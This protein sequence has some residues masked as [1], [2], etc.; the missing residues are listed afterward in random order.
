MR[1]LVSV[2]K[3][4]DKACSKPLKYVLARDICFSLS[5]NAHSPLASCER[6][7]QNTIHFCSVLVANFSFEFFL[8]LS[9]DS[10]PAHY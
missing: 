9:F 10:L 4:G 3:M 1:P 6:V 8:L 5:K 2:V 7:H